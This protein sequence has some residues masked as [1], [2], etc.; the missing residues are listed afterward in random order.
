MTLK[1]GTSAKFATVKFLWFGILACL[2]WT[3]FADGETWTQ[4]NCTKRLGQRISVLRNSDQSITVGTER[5]RVFLSQIPCRSLGDKL[6]L[7]FCEQE[8]GNSTQYFY[9]EFRHEQGFPGNDN[10]NRLV[11]RDVW[12]F[13]FRSIYP[14]TTG[15]LQS[16]KTQ[17]E[18]EKSECEVK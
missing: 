3:A 14:D 15:A 11:D 9:S 5:T 6:P 13:Y 4:V 7:F 2:V 10:Y 8:F 16:V 18:F 17:T 12:I 1:L